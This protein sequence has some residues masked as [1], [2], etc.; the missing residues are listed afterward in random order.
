MRSAPGSR[1][2]IFSGRQ[3]DTL[4]KEQNLNLTYN[5]ATA[6]CH[7]AIDNLLAGKNPYAVSNIITADLRFNADNEPWTKITPI[8]TGRFA[9]DFPYPS[10]TRTQGRVGPGRADAGGRPAG[11]GIKLN[12]PA[13]SF[14]LAAPFIW[15]GIGDLRWV[16]LLAV[17]AGIALAVVKA[18]AG[19]RLWLLGAALAS[20]EIWESIASGETGTIVFPFLLGAWLL[21]RRQPGF[22]LSAWGWLWPP[23]RWPGFSCLFI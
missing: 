3:T 13:G 17:I 21:W 12:Y 20:L 4:L 1:C 23:N 8:R 11:N 16:Y 6:L 22:R 18:P 19:M 15:A 2:R 14:L 9:T 7:Q 10:D 5:D